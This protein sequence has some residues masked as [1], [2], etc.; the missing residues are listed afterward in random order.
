MGFYPG[1]IYIPLVEEMEKWS[2]VA[3]DQ[4]TAQPDYWQR[5]EKRVGE[6]PSALRMIVP[7]CYLGTPQEGERVAA[8]A[9]AMRSYLEEGVFRA[10]TGFVYLRRTLRS[11]R[12]RQGLV[13]LLDLEQYDYRPGAQCPVRAT[14][15]TVLERIPPRVAVRRQALLECPHIMLLVD[16]PEGT[17]VEPTARRLEDLNQLY[18]FDLMEDSGH[19]QGYLCDDDEAAR[20]MGALRALS[21]KAP[22]LFAV[23]DGNH[24]LAAAKAYYEEIKQSLPPREAAVHPARYA[25]AEVVNLHD[26]A[27]DFAPIHRAVFDVDGE[28]LLTALREELDATPGQGGQGV[29]LC[30][31]GREE[32]LA[33]GKQLANLSV[34]TLQAFLDGYL[35]REGG[36]V[37]Y[38]HGA[39]VVRRLAR[40]EGCVGFLLEGMEK[41]SLFPAVAAGGALPRKT[42]SMGEAW[43][44]RF[45]LECRPIAAE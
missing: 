31:A 17:V 1:D 20:V 38:I 10:A 2:V 7:E 11:G 27:L 44:K 9:T 3:C 26:P 13:G 12:V 36:R 39:D 6:A 24:S 40:E 28:R 18:D 43:D 8:T 42:F 4:Y 15:G 35:A 30:L 33:F 32:R 16:D 45:Y 29:T 41:E 14:E 25:L 21:L 19:L 34:G 5:V 37:D 22:F 23:G